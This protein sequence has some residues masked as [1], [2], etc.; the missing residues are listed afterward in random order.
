MAGPLALLWLAAAQQ[1][2]KTQ[3]FSFPT[4]LGV[5][6]LP[7]SLKHQVSPTSKVRIQKIGCT[8]QITWFCYAQLLVRLL[9]GLLLLVLFVVVIIVRIVVVAAVSFLLFL[10]LRFSQAQSRSDAIAKPACL[11]YRYPHGGCNK[12]AYPPNGLFV[13]VPWCPC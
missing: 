13:Q 6:V 7:Q 10:V 5:R 4:R 1:E 3:G 11:A 12:S 8:H 9:L 2:T